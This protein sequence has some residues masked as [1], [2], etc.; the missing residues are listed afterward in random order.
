MGTANTTVTPG[1][2][3]INFNVYTPGGLTGTPTVSISQII[4]VRAKLNDFGAI[5]LKFVRHRATWLSVKV[6]VNGMKT[7]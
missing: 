6:I 1:T 5:V 2:T 3:I 4:G 7:Y